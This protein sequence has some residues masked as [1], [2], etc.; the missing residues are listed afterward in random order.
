MK[1]QIAV[2]LILLSYQPLF[3]QYVDFIK[4][5]G[6]SGYDDIRSQVYIGE[7]KIA[8]TGLTQSG[9]DP[10]G[11]VFL[12]FMD[13]KGNLLS[14][15]FYGKDKE[16]GG[17]GIIKTSDGGFLISGHTALPISGDE[18]DAMVTKLN[19]EGILEWQVN[20]G[21][22][23]DETSYSAIEALDGTYWIAG[24]QKDEKFD[25]QKAIIFHINSNGKLLSTVLAPQEYQRKEGL[26][27]VNKSASR[28][29]QYDEKLLIIGGVIPYKYGIENDWG[30]T[31]SLK[32]VIW[33]Y[34]CDSSNIALIDQY[35][36]NINYNS[37]K[38]NVQMMNDIILDD[39]KNKLLLFGAI[40][41]T[42]NTQIK[43]SFPWMNIVSILNNKILVDSTFISP[44]AN[45]GHGS[46]K[47]AEQSI[48]GNIYVVGDFQQ[49]LDTIP[50]WA[51]LDSNYKL[52]N[53][54]IIDLPEFATANNLS[55][56]ENN[57]IFIG[58]KAWTKDEYQMF[59][60]HLYPF[61]LTS[62]KDN[63][64]S[65]AS[66]F[67][68]PSNNEIT[69]DFEL[70]S[71]LLLFSLLNINGQKLFEKKMNGGINKIQLPDSYSGEYVYSIINC[72]N[73]RTVA[74]KI[75]IIK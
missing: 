20:L 54:S 21:G 32:P 47:D 75:Q 30:N 5:I 72:N 65:I 2:F 48:D 11:D 36:I 66:V 53:W 69:I 7:G 49:E 60:A 9:T 6:N 29:I 33:L 31:I 61:R 70:N 16:D 27:F 55:I 15:N 40:D 24:T 71:D 28:I 10:E 39:T 38:S 44:F 52:I 19:S 18:C 35:K 22:P 43:V 56:G 63:L 23:L 13:D 37:K 46:I 3:S 12:Y 17:N 8:F 64:N 45:F 67:P 62:N 50:F 14:T 34:H 4:L 26:N 41:T 59:I 58:G 51:V 68:N 73:R 57:D 25:Q 1:I 42:N 74:G